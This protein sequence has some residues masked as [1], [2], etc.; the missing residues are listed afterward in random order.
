VTLGILPPDEI[1]KKR[2][3]T[4]HVSEGQGMA[5]GFMGHVLDR[6]AHERTDRR[7]FVYPSFKSCPC[8]SIVER[9]GGLAHDDMA[10]ILTVRDRVNALGTLM[11]PEF[12]RGRRLLGS[13]S[14]PVP[15]RTYRGAEATGPLSRAGWPLFDLGGRH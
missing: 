11:L 10:P 2:K 3:V 12:R 7:V 5:C 4:A 13:D 6:L 14:G 15:P 8:C 9:T 1:H